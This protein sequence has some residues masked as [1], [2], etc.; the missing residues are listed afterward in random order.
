MKFIII[1]NCK[2]YEN[3][4]TDIFKQLVLSKLNVKIV[5][6]DYVAYINYENNQELKDIIYAFENSFMTS[7]YAYIS[8]DKEEDRLIDEEKIAIKLLDSLKPG[9]YTLKEALL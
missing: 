4:I 9:V 6:N 5:G 3:E 1:K 2:E 8:S 7:I